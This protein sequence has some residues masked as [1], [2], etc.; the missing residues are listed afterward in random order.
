MH[1]ASI[2]YGNIVK[3]VEVIDDVISIL[4]EKLD[5]LSHIDKQ[6]FIIRFE[7]LHDIFYS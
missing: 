4:G 1:F 3:V 5:S 7:R 6:A 2:T